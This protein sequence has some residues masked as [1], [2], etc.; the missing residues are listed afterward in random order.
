MHLHEFLIRVDISKLL[1]GNCINQTA[2]RKIL[3][4]ITSFSRIMMDILDEA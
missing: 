4:K 3:G 2:L 1:S